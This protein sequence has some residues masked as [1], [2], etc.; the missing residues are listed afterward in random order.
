MEVV[1]AAGAVRRAELQS[2]RYHQQI[3]TWLATA[4][5]SGSSVHSDSSPPFRGSAIPEVR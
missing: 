4:D 5:F 2:N 3:K 1:V